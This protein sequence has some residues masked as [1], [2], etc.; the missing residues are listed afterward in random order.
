MVEETL[1]ENVNYSPHP[2]MPLVRSVGI[3]DGH[4]FE[5]GLSAEPV[6]RDDEEVVRG[7]CGSVG[8]LVMLLCCESELLLSAVLV[9]Q[10][11]VGRR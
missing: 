3:E 5:G 4:L 8:V 1:V 2:S 11:N 10:L 7:E 9:D 6:Q